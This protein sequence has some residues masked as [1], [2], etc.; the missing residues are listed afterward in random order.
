MQRSGIAELPLHYG[1]CPRW[2]FTR[3]V[4]LSRAIV[5]IL[6]SE[7]SERVFLKRLSDP[8][9]FQAFS[10]AIGFDWHSSGVSTTLTG[11][12]K[13]ANLYDLGIGV[14]GGKGRASRKT[15]QELEALA[16]ILSLSIKAT[17]SLKKASY[18]T[19][20]VDTAAL[21]DGFDLYHHVIF[22]TERGEWAVVQQGLNTD[23]KYARRYHW[24]GGSME[25]F[26]E[27]PHSAI[28]SDLT[29]QALNLVARE[30]RGAQ[31]AI[32]DL[33]VENPT[34]TLRQLHKIRG[35]TTLGDFT[36]SAASSV[37]TFLAPRRHNIIPQEDINPKKLHQI[38]LQ[39]YESQVE[40]FESLL[41]V[42]G[43]G[44]ATIR[45]LALLSELL[46]GEEPSWR[47]PCRYSFCVGGKD[48]VPYTPNLQHYDQVIE[49]MQDL[50]RE[51]KLG[52]REKLAAIQRLSSSNLA[53]QT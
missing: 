36:P 40:D 17:N 23:M 13:A 7:Y 49:T 6:V 48:G 1:N 15:P 20:K 32:V 9:W 18:M 41:G 10:C 11:A 28:C 31:R 38:L 19:A 52:K 29:G 30:S 2:L 46:Y 33:A 44:P 43:L 37:S 14:C 8:Y 4:R 34:W 39:T 51:S 50:V 53:N 42:R 16:D 27:E 12:L 24:L 25:S 22:F 47:D 45:S 3:M 26:V 35:Q 5:E 21:Q